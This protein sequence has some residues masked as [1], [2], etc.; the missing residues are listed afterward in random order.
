MMIATGRSRWLLPPVHQTR[1]EKHN[2]FVQL[3]LED[4]SLYTSV[5][6]GLYILYDGTGIPGVVKENISWGSYKRYMTRR[7]LIV[8]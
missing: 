7:H 1:A 3:E 8:S 6:E 2:L 5:T 4:I